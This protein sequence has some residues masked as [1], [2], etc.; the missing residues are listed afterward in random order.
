MRWVLGCAGLVFVLIGGCVLVIF[1][2]GVAADEVA[3]A[4]GAAVV[5]LLGIWMIY[6]AVTRSTSSAG[7]RHDSGVDPS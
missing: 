2:D 5:L 1:S 3:F 4:I 6:S 7:D